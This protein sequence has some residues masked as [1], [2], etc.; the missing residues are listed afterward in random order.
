MSLFERLRRAGDAAEVEALFAQALVESP[1]APPEE[2]GALRRG[3]RLRLRQLARTEVPVA[4]PVGRVAPRFEGRLR[5]APRIRGARPRA[6]AIGGGFLAVM[7][8][9]AG[10]RTVWRLVKPDD[11]LRGP[12]Y[13]IEEPLGDLLPERYTLAAV[14]K[15]GGTVPRIDAL[16]ARGTPD[17]VAAKAILDELGLSEVHVRL[18][19]LGRVSAADRHRL[20]GLLHALGPREPAGGSR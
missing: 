12:S 13:R 7:V 9:M 11:A 8:L 3:A 17:P 6:A 19:L 16:L 18:I 5:K 2:V 15:W 20:V 1:L 10:A 14:P 4:T